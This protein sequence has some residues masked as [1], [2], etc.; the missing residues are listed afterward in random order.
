MDE[1]AAKEFGVYGELHRP[2][3]WHE[4]RYVVPGPP[5]SKLWQWQCTTDGYP[6]GSNVLMALQ[7]LCAT[8][9]VSTLVTK[10][11]KFDN[12]FKP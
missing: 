1:P 11:F 12:T 6:V 8:S 5:L 2:Q 10:G 4:V 7:A 3:R 9:W